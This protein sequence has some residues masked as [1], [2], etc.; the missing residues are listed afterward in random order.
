M[1]KIVVAMFFLEIRKTYFLGLFFSNLEYKNGSQAF[2]SWLSQWE[3]NLVL[4]CFYMNAVFGRLSNK[5]LP[6]S[7]QELNV[8]PFLL[9]SMLK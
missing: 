1:K 5:I 2:G 3:H 4:P 6:F 7:K 8:G 9:F